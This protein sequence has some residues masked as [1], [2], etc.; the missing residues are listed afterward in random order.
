M[1]LIILLVLILMNGIGYFNAPVTA[2]GYRY[3]S[4]G[5][6]LVLLILFILI[7]LHIVPANI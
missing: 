7:V 4:G 1:I 6:G 2:P 3:G 5:L